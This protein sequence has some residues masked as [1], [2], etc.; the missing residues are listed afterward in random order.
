MKRRPPRST[1]T[2]THLPYTTIFL[3][4]ADLRKPEAP[5][6]GT[7]HPAGRPRHPAPARRRQRRPHGGGARRR[8]R[9]PSDAEI[10]D[11][12]AVSRVAAQA[13]DS[14]GQTGE[15]GDRKSV[16]SGNSVSVREDLGGRRI[17][18]KKQ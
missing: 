16:V 2:D 9:V 7:A 6:R 11:G 15:T 17:I 18:K 3:S 5:G 4:L 12:A 14:H 1:R 13:H 10:R 8:A